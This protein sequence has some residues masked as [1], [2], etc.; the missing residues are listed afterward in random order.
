MRSRGTFAALGTTFE[1][2]GGRLGRSL[3]EAFADVASPRAA[4]HRLE[5]V[6]RGP[7]RWTVRSDGEVR[8]RDA[9][10]L[11]AQTAAMVAVDELALASV[12]ATD[13]VLYG[14]AVE[15]AGLAV[16]FVGRRRSVGWMVASSALRGHGY[17]TD[18][19]VAI[20]PEGLVRPFHRPVELRESALASLG[21]ERPAGT[22]WQGNALLRIG[23]RAPLSNGAPLG[24]I[25]FAE[26][27]SPDSCAARVP[28]SAALA[29][30]ANHA[31]AAT[32]HERVM[33]RRLEQ[34]VRR[35]PVI[36]GAEDD[37]ESTIDAAR[38]AI[39]R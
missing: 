35:V 39:R 30:L 33:F 5:V 21:R 36:V 14:G 25:V 31:V 29:R 20:D 37:I 1:V 17:V 23:G 27:N 8:A 12:A 24:L 4:E 18:G 34:L 6:R 13:T 26:Q 19:V 3:G 2:R 16:A 22:S 10:R 15:I 11:N 32:G 38:E 9:D 7:D 28:P